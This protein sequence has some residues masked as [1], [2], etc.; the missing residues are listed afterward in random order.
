M[1]ARIAAILA[2]LL[3]LSGLALYKQ[4]QASGELRAQIE[5]RDAWLLESARKAGKLSAEITARDQA[6]IELEAQKNALA[7][8]KE[9]VRD[10][11]RIVV[12]ESGD[13][14]I[15]A[16]VPVDV[17]RAVGAALDCLWE[18]AS[19][20]SNSGCGNRATGG[21]DAGLSPPER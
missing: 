6:I 1:T 17:A 15:K 16:S 14:C 11:V 3:A 8:R 18:P 20:T 19:A 21:D 2:L 13:A 5:Q 10:V 4:I 7:N 9:Q 12:D